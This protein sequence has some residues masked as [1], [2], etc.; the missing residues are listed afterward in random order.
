MVL[1]VQ[2]LCQLA[3]QRGIISVVDGAH[4]PVMV[5][6]NVSEIAADFYTGNCHKWLLAPTGSGFLVIGPNM[7]DRLEPGQVSWGYHH[8][9][10][11]ADERDE[12][13]ST[14]RLRFL[15]FE[16]TRDI[17]PWLAVP[18]AIDFQAKIGFDAIRDRMRELANYVR[19]QMADRL[20]FPV[21]T[22]DHPAMRGSLTAFELPIGRTALQW[23]EL[24][25]NKRIEAPVIERPER[26]LVRFST[27]FYDIESEIDKL[28][29]LLAM[30]EASP[31]LSSQ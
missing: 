23:R 25:W 16:G 10:R 11:Y 27:H 9:N 15:E 31:G 6:L 5:P 29:E 28:V 3:R 18:A 19:R 21:V 12:W 4:A 20:G 8:A 24:I 30:P 7:E 22:P 17:T 1:P 13:G 14:P 2:Q 26:L